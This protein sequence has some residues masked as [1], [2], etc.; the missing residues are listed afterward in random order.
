V[1]SICLPSFTLR[2]GPKER[3]AGRHHLLSERRKASAASGGTMCG[4]VSNRAGRSLRFVFAD[5]M[6]PAVSIV[7]AYLAS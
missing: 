6:E 4:S 1:L 7:N 5:N 3:V 2:S